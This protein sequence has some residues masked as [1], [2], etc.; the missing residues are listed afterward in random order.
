MESDSSLRGEVDHTFFSSDSE[1]GSRGPGTKEPETPRDQQG[2]GTPRA[3]NHVGGH[4]PVPVRQVTFGYKS[5]SDS[6]DEDAEGGASPRVRAAEPAKDAKL[7]TASGEDTSETGGHKE[8]GD[9]IETTPR[10]ESESHESNRSRESST[11]C[12]S[13]DEDSSAEDRKSIDGR[14]AQNGAKIEDD[15]KSENK[16]EDDAKSESDG[17]LESETKSERGAQSPFRAQSANHGKPPDH[18]NSPDGARSRGRSSSQGSAR[19]YRDSSSDTVKSRS[20][21]ASKKSI[22][23]RTSAK[24][25]KSTGSRARSQA[26]QSR[27]EHGTRARASVKNDSSSSDEEDHTVAGKAQG[28]RKPSPVVK[29]TSDSLD[30]GPRSPRQA[31][32]SKKQDRKADIWQAPAICSTAKPVKTAKQSSSSAISSSSTL[33]PLSSGVEG[34]SGGGYRSSRVLSEAE[35]LN[36][37]LKAVVAMET[38]P[39]TRRAPGEGSSA[40]SRVLRASAYGNVRRPLRSNYSFSEEQV[41]R[42]DRDNQRLLERL[43]RLSLPPLPPPPVRR[44]GSGSVVMVPSRPYHTA[45]TRERALRRIQEENMLI[46]RRLEAVRPT[47]GLSRAELLLQYSRQAAYMG[48]PS[49]APSSPPRRARR[50]GVHSSV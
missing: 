39:K 8:E 34:Q 42:I 41:R 46:L 32:A 21:T 9:D 44:A 15:V 33:S 11:S 31:K 45:V 6:V 22:A 10:A 24:S 7:D 36:H 20:S 14:T 47:P 27:E 3:E 40:T 18:A 29:S 4:T 30:G 48:G 2:T 25:K 12:S 13:S 19:S 5:D 38:R 17:K 37:L 28:L 23:S 26:S 1:A 49:W 16:M 43:C 50:L 35:D